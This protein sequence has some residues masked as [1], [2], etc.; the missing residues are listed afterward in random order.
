MDSCTLH[1]LYQTPKSGPR[2]ELLGSCTFIHPT[3]HPKVGREGNSWAAFVS[4]YVLPLN[5]V[6]A[7]HG[8]VMEYV[9]KYSTTTIL[10]GGTY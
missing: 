9:P 10:V 3:K 6:R 1:T 7:M 5:V 2:R 8:D 4:Y